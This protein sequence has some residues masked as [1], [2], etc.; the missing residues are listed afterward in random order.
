MICQQKTNTQLLLEGLEENHVP[1]PKSE[2]LEKTGVSEALI[3]K[4]EY[5][6][7][8]ER[9]NKERVRQYYLIKYA[10]FKDKLK[11]KRARPELSAKT[12]EYQKAYRQ[13]HRARLANMYRA[14]V[15][16][17]RERI[18]AYRQQF[19]DRRI[20]LY[21]ARKEEICA[22]K[23][24]LARTPKYRARIQDY[25]RR[26]R[27]EDPLFALKDALRASTGRAF[28][29][30][31]IKKP[32]RTEAL[33]GCT[34]AEAKAHIESQFAPGMSWE[35]RSSFVLDHFLPIAAFDLRDSEEVALAFNWRNLRPITQHENSV[36][37]AT[38][39]LPLPNWLPNHIQ[40]RIKAR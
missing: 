36:K 19:N 12:R 31:W 40:E 13:K 15:L 28:R 22:R 16:K 23:R 11:A 4:R 7:E 26:R 9:K 21:H 10:K 30:Q 38:I 25:Q 37:S 17:N 39:P 24:E 34:I 35:N 27:R 6:R 20:E 14:W 5:H 29:R 18:A 8:W 1:L 32:A 3:K 2:P 33:L